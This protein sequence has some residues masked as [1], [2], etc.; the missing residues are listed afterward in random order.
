MSFLLMAKRKTEGS[1]AKKKD[2]EDTF[3]RLTLPSDDEEEIKPHFFRII[4]SPSL[5][6]HKL[7]LPPAFTKENGSG[8]SG[9]AY[10]RAPGGK[11]HRVT[12]LK[13]N[14]DIWFT[15][16]WPCF[17]ELYS[18][19]YGH[20]LVFRYQG[21]S[22]FNVFIFDVSCS[23]IQYPNFDDT[24]SDDDEDWD[25]L[26]EDEEEE[27]DNELPY[28]NGRMSEQFERAEAFK[29]DHPRFIVSMHVSY[30]SG[31]YR[32]WVPLR[33]S[34]K[35]LNNVVDGRKSKVKFCLEGK[36]WSVSISR[37][38][39]N[40][41]R[42]GPNGWRKF[43]LQNQLKVDDVCVFELIDKNVLSYMTVSDNKKDIPYCAYY[44]FLGVKEETET[45]RGNLTLPRSSNVTSL[46]LGGSV[47]KTWTPNSKEK[48]TLASAF[49]IMQ[50]YKQLFFY[51]NNPPLSFTFT[52][53]SV[54]FTTVFPR[55]EVEEQQCT[56]YRGRMI[57]FSGSFIKK[58]LSVPQHWRHE[59]PRSE[60]K[61]HWKA[62]RRGMEA[63]WQRRRDPQPVPTL[64][65][66]PAKQKLWLLGF[67]GQSK[68]WVF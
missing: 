53:F 68:R 21:N 64:N 1:S 23:E 49:T 61:E 7:M 63:Q 15:Q 6:L 28:G 20:F 62:Q 12:L 19:A 22:R 42:L 5:Q 32:V 54:P 41:M 37:A 56:I 29:C 51:F 18:L 31:E 60:E 17:C 16:G 36:S 44:I 25:E 59:Q 33:H 10:L 38:G 14:G 47:Q 52:W 67:L 39:N 2:V 46:T 4:I 35:Y 11:E 27:S 13:R 26:D 66:L 48:A 65:Q 43:V 45:T 57:D 58:S 50:Q 34:L 55:L 30:V 9:Y 24:S 8:L 3:M 40:C